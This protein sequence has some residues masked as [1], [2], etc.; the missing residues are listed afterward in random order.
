MK[1]R[2]LQWKSD[3]GTE[4]APA[5]HRE[6]LWAHTIPASGQRLRLWAI[7]VPP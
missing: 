1:S 4:N 7:S 2:I 6:P 3:R 5:C